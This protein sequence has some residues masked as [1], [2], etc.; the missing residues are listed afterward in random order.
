M[1]LY[2]L[3]DEKGQTHNS[4]QW[5]PGVRHEAT[6]MGKGLCSDGWIHAYEDKY[7]AA[8]LSPIHGGFSKPQL[9]LAEGAGELLRDGQRKCGVIPNAFCIDALM[10]F[11]ACAC[12]R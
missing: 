3:T 9:W 5:G 7:V 8:L 10:S 4:T 1:R 2:K 6:G 11:C 12:W